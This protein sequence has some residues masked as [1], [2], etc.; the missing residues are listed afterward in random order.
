MNRIQSTSF[1]ESRVRARWRAGEPALCTVVQLADPSVVE[2]VAGL[3]FDCIWL[4]LEHSP[5]SAETASNLMRAARQGDTDILARPGKGEFMRMGRLL[6][7]GA[8]GIL[9][10]RCESVEEAREVVRWAKFAPMGERG[11][12]G[13]NSDAGYGSPDVADY[14]AAANRETFLCVQIESPSA[15]PHAR[16][17][18]EVDGV[19]ALFF[20]PGD[21]SVLTGHPGQPDHS[22][23]FQ[24]CQ[25][26][27]AAALAAGKRFATV[28]FDQDHAKRLLA[29]GATFLHHG[30]DIRILRGTYVNMRGYLG[31]MGFRFGRSGQP[32]SKYVER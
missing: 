13:S 20:G 6:E 31:E 7:A 23:V 21:Y 8:N 24:A 16:A 27:C 9:Y 3:G 19:D 12:S 25:E 30:V 28:T 26:V 10:P 4:D 17:I 15:L 5:M 29:M 11:F 14:I 1:R 22:S 32:T 2:L 18:A